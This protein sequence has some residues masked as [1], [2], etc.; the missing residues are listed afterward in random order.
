MLHY[1]LMCRASPSQPDSSTTT[2][3][4]P[5][6]ALFCYQPQTC[7]S[8]GQQAACCR[9][10]PA[11]RHRAPAARRAR[12]PVPCCPPHGRG[13]RLLLSQAPASAP[14]TPAPVRH[15]RGCAAAPR[16]A[17][18][19][20]ARRALPPG[21]RRPPLP[22]DTGTACFPRGTVPGGPL[23][24]RAASAGPAAAPAGRQG[25]P[26][27]AGLPG[28][29]GGGAGAG[30]GRGGGR[31]S[32]P[33]GAWHRRSGELDWPGTCMPAPRHVRPVHVCTSARAGG[34][35]G[36][37]SLIGPAR[38]CPPLGT[39]TPYMCAPRRVHPVHACAH[40]G[41]CSI[42][43]RSLGTC[44]RGVRRSGELD[45]LG[46]CLP[47]PQRVHPVHM[48][49]PRHVH[50]VHV[51]TSANAPRTCVHFGTCPPYMCLA[52][53]VREGCAAERG[54]CLPW[55][56]LPAPRH[57]HGGHVCKS[58]RAGGTGRDRLALPANTCRARLRQVRTA[59]C[60]LRHVR[61]AWILGWQ[62]ERERE[63]LHL[64]SYTGLMQVLPGHPPQ[65]P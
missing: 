37:G 16:R 61:G 42:Y 23:G 11:T 38:A 12:P 26:G 51:C 54:A 53:H 48:C 1:G 41:T 52:R 30:R 25:I 55:R 2:A 65:I 59:M 49:A 35:C 24:L 64:S 57:V 46:T 4:K 17:S 47:A 33:G 34:T 9:V 50:P 60:A 43:R 39:C 7:H 19:P 58:A 32:E 45:W 40:L 31:W 10:A 28:G 3:S 22:P 8:T 44:G 6:A 14:A 15:A 13:P 56:C 5:A 29:G 18:P 21:H 36:A 20:S 27:A 62:C 63:S